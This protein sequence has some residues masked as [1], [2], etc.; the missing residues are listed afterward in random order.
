MESG[1]IYI[2]LIIGIKKETKE[3]LFTAYCPDLELATCAKA[4]EEAEK[5]ID[6][7]IR[8]VLDTATKRGELHDLLREYNI[9]LHLHKPKPP[10]LPL[11]SKYWL[12]PRTEKVLV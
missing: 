10:T 11:E 5:H 7:A 6:D 9:P 3:D 2:S 4:F 1:E 8:L 12:A